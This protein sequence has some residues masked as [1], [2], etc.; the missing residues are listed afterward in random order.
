[1]IEF[2]ATFLVAMLS[3]VV[4]IIIMNAIFYRPILNIVKKREDY[5]SENYNQAKFL[6]EKTLNL[7]NSKEEQLNNV[8]VD[9]R[10]RIE[11]AIDTAQADS[12][13]KV[14]TQKEETK[15]QIQLEKEKLIQQRE[16]IRA[17]LNSSVV[18]DLSEVL[19]NKI[20][21]GGKNG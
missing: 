3:F 11:T 12:N 17:A 14:I 5:I 13:K 18:S 16:D 2:N 7:Q 4:F 8:R 20:L 9:C 15:K 6:D 10:H 19:T 21:K 1:M